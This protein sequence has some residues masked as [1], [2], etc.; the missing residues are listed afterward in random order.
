MQRQETSRDRPGSHPLATEILKSSPS[1]AL[2]VPD[3]RCH[4]RSES[5]HSKW[6]LLILC[7]VFPFH[8]MTCP[9]HLGR[10]LNKRPPISESEHAGTSCAWVPGK[11][12][13]GS[14]FTSKRWTKPPPTACHASE[15]DAG[16]RRQVARTRPAGRRKSRHSTPCSQSPF[17][18]TAAM[19]LASKYRLT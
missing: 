16:R 2:W 14:R 10:K 6:L 11:A 19:R 13:K 15:G 8:V 9:S 7:H 3:K 1:P 4:T 18:G 5:V 12:P 17:G